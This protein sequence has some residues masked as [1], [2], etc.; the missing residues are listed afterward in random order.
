MLNAYFKVIPR[1]LKNFLTNDSTF[2]I[3]SLYYEKREKLMRRHRVL[4][5]KGVKENDLKF[6]LTN[7]FKVDI[8]YLYSETN[9]IESD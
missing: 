9:R 2:C 6:F 5:P 7:G 8:I 3:I 1:N 4:S